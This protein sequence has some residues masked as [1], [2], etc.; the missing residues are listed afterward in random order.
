[1]KKLLTIFALMLVAFT[2]TQMH[3]ENMSVHFP[4]IT[5]QPGETAEMLVSY[6]TDYQNLSAFQIEFELPSG[7]H[8]A[9][10]KLADGY[11]CPENYF[12]F[13]PDRDGTAVIMNILYH[14]GTTLPSGHQ[15]FLVLTFQADADA[16][17]RTYDISTTL[18]EFSHWGWDNADKYDSQTFHIT[19][20]TVAP[21]TNLCPDSHHPHMIDLGLP[22]G[23]KW[24]CCNVGADKPEAY[25]G[26][27]AWGE[28][29]E[30]DYFDQEN[31][32][33]FEGW[34][35][36]FDDYGDE[37]N[38]V[39]N[40]DLGEDIAGT[41]YDVAHV[42]WGAS[43]VMPS[44]EQQDELINNCTYEWTTV[45]G[46]NG[47]KF[48]S[49]VNGVS[50]FLP[51]AGHHH[52]GAL[53]N[54]G[55][56]GFFWSSTQ[57]P[58]AS[59]LADY[60]QLY[61]YSNDIRASLSNYDRDNGQSVRPVCTTPVST[62]LG[63]VNGDGEVNITDVVLTVNHILGTSSSAF[64]MANADVNCDGDVNITDVVGMVGIIL[65]ESEDL[66]LQWCLIAHLSNDDT[67]QIPMKDVGS[68]ASLDDASDFSVLDT[69][70]DTLAY[71]VLK[72][73]FEMRIV[74]EDDDLSPAEKEYDIPVT[75]GSGGIGTFVT[76]YNVDGQEE[77][78]ES[79]G[80]VFVS[81]AKGRNFAW[82]ADG[83]P[84]GDYQSLGSRYDIKHVKEICRYV[85]S[86]NL[87]NLVL[88]ED[89]AISQSDV[90]VRAYGNEI[91]PSQDNV[92]HT[93][94]NAVSVMDKQGRMIYECYAS[95]DTLEAHRVIDINA[96]ET[97]YSFLLPLF[98]FPFD[99]TPDAILERLKSL[100]AELPETHALAAAIDRSILRNG[101]LE[102]EE[103]ETECNAAKDAII[104]KLGLRNNYLKPGQTNSPRYKSRAEPQLLNGHHKYGI[105]VE[106]D[107]SEWYEN[108][109][110]WKCYFTAY[111]SN[112]FAY[113][114]WTKG[115]RD[116]N[117]IAYLYEFDIK[118]LYKSILKP[119]RLKTFMDSF[120]TWEGF[121][122]F[123]IDS[124]HLA[125]Y[126]D[127]GIGDMTWDKT[128]KSFDLDFYDE[129][130]ILVAI[131]PAD[132]DKM[133][134]YNIMK[135][136]IQPVAKKVV[137]KALDLDDED[138]FLN[139]CFDEALDADFWNGLL[140]IKSSNDS[141]GEKAVE[142]FK[143]IWPKLEDQLKKYFEEELKTKAEQFVWD[144]WGFTA[145]GDLQHAFEVIDNNKFYWLKKIEF[146]G[147]LILGIIGLN[148]GNICYEM[149]LNF[150]VEDVPAYKEDFVVNGVN[151]SMVKVRGGSFNMGAPKND[152]K[153]SKDEKPQHKVTLDNFA[154]G[155]TEVTQALWE[156][157]MGNNPS[158][159]KGPDLPV[160]NVSWYDCQEFINKLNE[161]KI[162]EGQF[163][164][165]TEAEWEYAARGGQHSLGNIYAGSLQIKE[166]AW[167]EENSEKKTHPVKGLESNEL[168]IYDMSGNVMEW[169]QDYWAYG[170]YYLNSPEENPCCDNQGLFGDR[171]MR[172]GNWHWDEDYC[173]VYDRSNGAPGIKCEIYG[174]RLALTSEN[175]TDSHLKCPDEYHP[176]MID[177]GLPSGTKWACC[178]VEADYP[179]DKGGY[180]AWGETE[181]KL[182]YDWFSYTL[183]DTYDGPCYDLRP[184]ICGLQ[185]Y[186]VAR[187]QWGEMWQMP[188][189]E[190]MEELY[191]NCTSEW[192]MVHKTVGRL[193]TGP[194]GGSI[195]LPA[196]GYCNSK[197][198]FEDKT[199][200]NYWSGTQKADYSG[201]NS[202]IAKKFLFSQ[203]DM[204]I[205]EE[206][207]CIG[208]SVRP[209]VSQ[210]QTYLT[211]PD[212]HHPHLIDLGLPSGTKW[213]CCNVDDDASKQTPTNYGSY[214]AWG[215]TEE[216]NNYNWR[217][218]T[219]CDGSEDTCHDLGS[220]IAGT[221]YDVA[222]VKW[223]GSWVMPTHD[224]KM[225]L[226]DNCTYEL[227]TVNGVNGGRFT[228]KTNG[229]SIFLPA[230]GYR[231][232]DYLSR[233]GMYGDYWSSTQ[234]P[235]YSYDA[236]YLFFGSGGTLWDSGDHRYYGFTVR[237]VSR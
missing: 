98:P 50:I 153:A 10:A 221:Q 219:H 136:L 159:F 19:V 82:V 5:L 181:G 60:L 205:V 208:A 100:L 194:N 128:K 155:E 216:K 34:T 36:W 142:L 218:Y 17:E 16:E 132:N 48:T 88:P 151:F 122:D 207:R 52:V 193:F 11:S 23:T 131:G 235:S 214:Y 127:F 161:L 156:A 175:P 28:T 119:Q 65:G 172:G 76:Y 27:Y 20:G 78:C 69:Q 25:G 53:Y 179:E 18:I 55:S 38:I 224:Q 183:M 47:V 215:E 140:A 154:I 46:V 206:N 134:L 99:T 233:A 190:Q 6:D 196:A 130:E 13:N 2:A 188:S 49:K 197:F 59:Y 3:A 86:D 198:Y 149:S 79:K 57:D 63:D 58:R 232:G 83:M 42:K 222:H 70:G 73:T 177:L 90:V 22:S 211:C 64:N 84:Q 152:K 75:G 105:Y 95:A 123:F 166:V 124:W 96:M 169:C 189:Q 145:A 67:R 26:Y 77:E 35:T 97:A 229:G 167:Y 227:T 102:I 107:N 125:F 110:S 146:A 33:F 184:G 133:Y 40:T 108:L 109:H 111:N 24:A 209:I 93:D 204:S 56:G 139:F 186:D 103:I 202:R 210:P 195:F 12:G 144:R 91:D 89:A 174:L 171:V 126:P 158:K 201:A 92:Y 66:N 230:A 87:F 8:L 61:F 176:H 141:Y 226:L 228:S 162:T 121:S 170:D 68:L 138:Y 115:Y 29:E 157:V 106:L 101:Y 137:K 30:K 185:Q 180:Y 117:G 45:N 21:V 41:Q 9:D 4:D 74:E 173:K 231:W 217:T 104:E 220:D 223:G 118:K 80:M 148:E 147:D 81:D 236:Y 160:D 192:T 44:K 191:Q 62:I 150:G 32:E 116:E 182:D 203:D 71:G 129:K 85:K 199:S 200:G 15:D 143:L 72:A 39:I 1:M 31:Y 165:P 94:A 112:M 234:H 164:F 43:W 212:D 237:P 135:S 14:S 37:Y 7:I 187:A 163:R 225:E 113:M 120:T 51:A 213:A 54:V 168:G 114:A 178:N